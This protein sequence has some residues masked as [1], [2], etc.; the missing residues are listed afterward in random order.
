M[1]SK[2][3]IDNRVNDKLEAD[4]LEEEELLDLSE[5]DVEWEMLDL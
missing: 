1:D 3:V 2:L 5:S 4:E